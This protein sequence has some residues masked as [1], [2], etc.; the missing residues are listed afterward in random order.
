MLPRAKDFQ[1]APGNVHFTP[2]GYQYLA[3][4]VAAAIVAALE[5][6]TSPVP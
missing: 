1:K 4:K 3:R 6:H 5:D 2:E